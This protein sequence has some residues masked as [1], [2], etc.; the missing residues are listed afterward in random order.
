MKVAGVVARDIRIVDANHLGD[1]IST[2]VYRLKSIV[3]VLIMAVCV[4]RAIA[5]IPN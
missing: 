5:L 4:L 2:W 3:Q 1:R